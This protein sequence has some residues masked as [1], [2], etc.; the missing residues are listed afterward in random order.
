VR[1]RTRLT[2]AVFAITSVA[3][4]AAAHAQFRYPPMY[5]YPASRYGYA[6]ADLRVK[7]KPKE[8]AVY[9]DGFYAGKVEDYD[10]TFERLHVEPGQHEIIV[11]LDGYR[12]LHQRLYLSPNTTRKI[13]GSLEKLAPG[14]P[15]DQPPQPSVQPDRQDPGAGRP[16][17]VGRGTRRAPPPDERNRTAPP[18]SPSPNSSRFGTI[19]VRVQPSGSTVFVDGERWVGPA[20]QDERLIIQVPAGPHRIEVERDGYERFVTEIDVTAAGTTPV[21]VSLTRSR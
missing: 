4:P 21:N 8:A 20:N 17:I 10:G 11:F 19:S 1:L 14:D 16:P 18:T 6:E 5:P 3:I 2:V 13:E 15:Q 7:V 9:I 12:S